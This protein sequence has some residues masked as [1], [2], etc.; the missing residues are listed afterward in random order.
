M[1]RAF[2]VRRNAKKVNKTRGF[3]NPSLAGSCQFGVND[4][5]TCGKIDTPLTQ[6]SS[7]GVP[8]LVVQRDDGMWSIGWHD[9]ADGPFP[10]R[11]FAEAVGLRGTRHHSILIS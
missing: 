2:V 11:N 6:R 9:D 3:E 1:A 8:P 4:A 10:T 7:R 5:G